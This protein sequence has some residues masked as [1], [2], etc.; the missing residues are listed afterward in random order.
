[1]ERDEGTQVAEPN[2]EQNVEE[3]EA[4]PKEQVDYDTKLH[5]AIAQ[6]KAE[7]EKKYKSLQRV[8]D[9]KDKQIQKLSQ[10][11]SQSTKALEAMREELRA[12][13]PESPRIQVIDAEIERIKKEG[14]TLKQMREVEQYT[15]DWRTKLT[16]KIEEAGLDPED[17]R[18]DDVW[19]NFELHYQI[20]G[21][22]DIAERKLDKILKGVNKV[23]EEPKKEEA[24]LEKILEERLKEEKRKW[25][26]ENGLT[27]KETGL[28]SGTTRTFTEEQIEA[29]SDKEY[30]KNRESILEAYAAGNVRKRQPQT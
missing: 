1:M 25:M 10:P 9:K 2:E 24:N 18:F 13:D 11:Q 12:N 14:E 5:E 16:G 4:E 17:D 27:E 20:D 30:A 21:K 19:E 28:P 3:P 22:F 29:M 23:A 8:I 26:E 15:E 7:S 6:V